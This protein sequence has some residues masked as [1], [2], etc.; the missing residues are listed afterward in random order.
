MNLYKVWPTPGKEY[1]FKNAIKSFDADCKIVWDKD[2]FNLKTK[3]SEADVKLSS[4]ERVELISHSKYCEPGVYFTETD[5]SEIMDRN[6]C[7]EIFLPQDGIPI[8]KDVVRNDYQYPDI[9]AGTAFKTP[10]KP[11]DRLVHYDYETGNLFPTKPIVPSVTIYE[12][13]CINGFIHRRPINVIKGRV[14]MGARPIKDGYKLEMIDF[15]TD[16]EKDSGDK[17]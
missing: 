10:F 6:P 8:A 11:L 12:T 13:Y 2:H 17:I 16:I 9:S 1:H 14:S 4:V 5:I 15:D 7:R 3:L